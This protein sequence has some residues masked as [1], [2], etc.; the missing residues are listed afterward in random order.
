M[1]VDAQ[2]R[3]AVDKYTLETPLSS[4]MLL[5]VR[6]TVDSGLSESAE[7]GEFMSD[8]PDPRLS[9]IKYLFS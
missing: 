9:E 3:A 4:H 2:Y 6:Y 8:K 1:D 5:Q 7:T